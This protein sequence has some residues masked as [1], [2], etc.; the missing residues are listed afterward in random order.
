MRKPLLKQFT[1]FTSKADDVM[2]EIEIRNE[3]FTD[4]VQQMKPFLQ[5]AQADL[6]QPRQEALAALLKK[7]LG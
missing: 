6:L 1:C 3:Q 5:E 4:L 7:A 2:P